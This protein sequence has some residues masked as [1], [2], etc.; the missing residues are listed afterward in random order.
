MTNVRSAASV[1]LAEHFSISCC[2][3][4]L[5]RPAPPA[6]AQLADF[7]CQFDPIRRRLRNWQTFPASSTQSAGAFQ[8]QALKCSPGSTRS[9]G[10]CA[11]G[12]LLTIRS[13]I[14][15]Q[16]LSHFPTEIRM[17]FAIFI[18]G[19]GLFGLTRSAGDCARSGSFS[20]SDPVVFRELHL[21]TSL[22]ERRHM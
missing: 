13:L 10:D 9:A 15:A 4:H 7:F 19:L 11:T 17:F 3:A 2:Y 14:L 6:I 1:Q 18:F 5:D 8:S 16:D 21:R 12:R 20:D 22:V